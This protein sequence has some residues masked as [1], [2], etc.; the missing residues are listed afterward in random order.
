MSHTST[1]KWAFLNKRTQFRL[2]PAHT[3]VV[4]TWK[5]FI[6]IFHVPYLWKRDDRNLKDY[7]IWQS[8]NVKLFSAQRSRETAKLLQIFELMKAMFN[9]GGNTR[10]R[11]ASVRHH[12]GNSLDNFLKIMM[13]SSRFF[14][15]T[16]HWNVC[17]LLPTSQGGD[18]EG[19]IFEHSSKSF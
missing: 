6:P 9:C 17:E 3:L 18:K 7:H 19:Q 10:Q 8:S 15:E 13:Q 1:V 2:K 11:L 4:E 12:E 14:R 16:Q 5:V